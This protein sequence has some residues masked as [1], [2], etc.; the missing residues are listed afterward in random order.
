M[1]EWLRLLAVPVALAAIVAPQASSNSTYYRYRWWICAV[2]AIG[3]LTLFGAA[4]QI[5]DQACELG[6]PSQCEDV[7]DRL[8]DDDY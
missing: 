8:Y 2:L 3:A 1:D 6:S 4:D 5:E 7:R